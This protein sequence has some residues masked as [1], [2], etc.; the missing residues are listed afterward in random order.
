MS[1]PLTVTRLLQ[2]PLGQP[3]PEGAVGDIVAISDGSRTLYLTPAEYDAATEAELHYRLAQTPFP[4]SRS[5][6]G[7]GRAGGSA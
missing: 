7:A 6:G 3:A 2:N 4:P 1:R 5:A